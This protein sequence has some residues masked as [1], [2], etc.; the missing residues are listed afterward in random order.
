MLARHRSCPLPISATGGNP[1]AAA[2]IVIA[3]GAVVSCD[4]LPT[5]PEPGAADEVVVLMGVSHRASSAIVPGPTGL[6]VRVTTRLAN[7]G[8]A[9]RVVSFGG[10]FFRVVLYAPGRSSGPPLWDLYDP[11]RTCR[12][13][14]FAV[15]L[16]PGESFELPVQVSVGSMLGRGIP[17]PR[18]PLGAARLWGWLPN[19]AYTIVLVLDTSIGSARLHAGELRLA[20]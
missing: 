5:V 12:T 16:N 17:V 10:C 20:L 11:D 4:S 6:V 19:G 18:V 3:L 7:E 9:P 15:P 14:A 13:D 8:S 1:R 2:L